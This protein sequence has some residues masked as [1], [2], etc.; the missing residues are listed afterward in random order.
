MCA[1]EDFSGTHNFAT[2]YQEHLNNAARY[3]KA[4]NERG[5]K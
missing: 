1:K 3:A 2:S 5:I 4:L